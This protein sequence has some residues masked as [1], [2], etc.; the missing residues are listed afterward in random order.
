MADIDKILESA[1]KQYQVNPYLEDKD[2]TKEDL[3]D[4]FVIVYPNGKRREVKAYSLDEIESY[5]NAWFDA[6]KCKYS[7]ED[8]TFFMK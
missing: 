6:G 7:F 8:V 3:R 4:V 2:A 1:R 5:V